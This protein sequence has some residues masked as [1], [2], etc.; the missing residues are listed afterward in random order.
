MTKFF[1]N[2]SKKVVAPPPPRA[3]VDIEK[4]YNEL[5]GRVADSQY[6]AYVHNRALE[7]YDQRMLSLNQEGAARKELDAKTETPE[8]QDAKS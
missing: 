3:M 1:R 6:Q 5:R 8:K 2:K 7:E 4:E